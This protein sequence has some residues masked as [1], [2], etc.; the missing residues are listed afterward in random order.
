MNVEAERA[1]VKQQYQQLQQA[2]VCQGLRPKTIDAYSRA[3]R[4]VAGFFK[5]CPDNLTSEELKRYFAALVDS[6]S[7]STVKLDRNGIQLFYR[8]VLHRPWDWVE[9]VKPPRVQRLPDVLSVQETFKLI[10]A[11][12]KL[13]YRVFFLTVYSMGLRLGEGLHSRSVTSTPAVYACTCVAAKATRTV[14]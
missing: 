7:W 1:R 13:R 14:P 12:R 10:N 6:H 2:L 5:R 9:I 4:R 8:H 11:T 3:V